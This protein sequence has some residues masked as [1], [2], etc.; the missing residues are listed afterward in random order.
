MKSSS[1]T[2]NA[3]VVI[4]EPMYR[5]PL[6]IILIGIFSLISPFQT[7]IGITISSF[8]LFLLIQS[9]TL[10][11]KFTSEDLIVMQLGKEIR[12]FPFKNWLAWRIFLP[13]LPGILYFRETASPHLLPILFDRTMLETQL[14]LRV[15]S[16][17]IT[18]K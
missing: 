8:G 11:L 18:Q 12:C 9:F 4:L 17:E 7:W 6:L 13:Q 10:R 16:K 15:G 2:D 5:L 1:P 3:E 14:K